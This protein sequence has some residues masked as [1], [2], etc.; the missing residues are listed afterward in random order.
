[1]DSWKVLALDATKEGKLGAILRCAIGE[2]N[3]R[4]PRFSSKAVITSDR[5]VMASFV[6]HDGE[7]HSGAFVGSVDDL[8]RNITDLADY[9]GLVGDDRAAMFTAFKRW[10]QTDYSLK[11]LCL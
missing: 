3:N 7:H 4:T 9:L 2:D 5:Y 8:E 10:I 1:M 6:D 11:G